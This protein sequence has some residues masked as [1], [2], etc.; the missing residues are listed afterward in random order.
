MQLFLLDNMVLKRTGLCTCLPKDAQI[1][2]LFPMIFLICTSLNTARSVITITENQTLREQEKEPL[3]N[4]IARQSKNA[5][6]EGGISKMQILVN[7]P[8]HAVPTE[9]SPI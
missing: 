4:E 1:L 2:I 8:I 6:L 9:M 3:P 5:L 7:H